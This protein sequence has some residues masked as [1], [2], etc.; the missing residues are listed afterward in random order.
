MFKT[1]VIDI[2]P[3]NGK[4]CIVHKPTLLFQI[5]E[6]TLSNTFTSLVV[7]KSL[8]HAMLGVSSQRPSWFT[9]LTNG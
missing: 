3:K 8:H 4:Y 9:D 6:V 2:D 7:L 1:C 5:S